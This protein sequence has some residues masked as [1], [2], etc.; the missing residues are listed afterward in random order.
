MVL[1]VILVVVI[2]VMMTYD[3]GTDNS[4]SKGGCGCGDQGCGGGSNT[5]RPNVMFT[6]ATIKAIKF[7]KYTKNLF[8]DDISTHTI[9]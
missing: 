4:N 7:V 6:D 2:V 1:V 5:T 3:N 8:S 9:W